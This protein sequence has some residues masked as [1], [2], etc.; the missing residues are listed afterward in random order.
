MATYKGI[1]GYTV[2][3]LS[4]DPT[5]S[6]AVGQLWYNNSTGKFKISTEGT[7]VWSSAA[8]LNTGRKEL[9]N[10]G[11]GTQTA[12]LTAGGSDFSVNAETYDGTSWTE[13]AN[14]NV[15]RAYIYGFGA[16]NTAGLMVA[17]YNPWGTEYANSETWNGTSWTEGANINTARAG[18]AMGGTAT[19]GFIAGGYPPGP[20]GKTETEI[21]NGTSWTETG[22][23][24][25]GRYVPGGGGT[26]TAGLCIGG[27]PALDTT[28]EFNGTSWS[29]H[30]ATQN[31]GKD[32]T[33]SCG[34]QSDAINFCDGPASALTEKF[35]GTTWT[36]VADLSTAR[37]AAG[38]LDG[39]S[40]S[41]ALAIAN[42]PTST[43][44]EVWDSPNYTIKTVTVS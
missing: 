28:F 35:D 15:S 36:E 17:G 33:L 40:G 18:G 3:S 10:G 2:K 42:A 29:T 27:Y 14:L 9:E 20:T 11:F 4:S 41:A 34:S 31:T 24:S 26:Q 21:Y 13:V 16:T 43:I 12:A 22:D 19:A 39:G 37:Y 23:L 6:E 30:P 1:Q 38:T 8:S 5:D 44:V 25:A 7:G 32:Y